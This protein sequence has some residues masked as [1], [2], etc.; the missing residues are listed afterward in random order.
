MFY[1]LQ[2]VLFNTGVDDLLL[3]LIWNKLMIDWHGNFPELLINYLRLLRMLFCE[4]A[5]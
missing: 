3:P 1:I 5:I 4:F 2:N